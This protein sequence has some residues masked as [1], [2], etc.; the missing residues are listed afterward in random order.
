MSGTTITPET[1]EY[2]RRVATATTRFMKAR[3]VCEALNLPEWERQAE[4]LPPK[5]EQK[6]DELNTSA[7]ELMMLVGADFFVQLKREE[8]L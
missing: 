4:D 2:A 1:L 8:A 5:V 6:R 3:A 7:Y